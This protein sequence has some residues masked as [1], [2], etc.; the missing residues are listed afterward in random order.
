ML[1]NFIQEK[2]LRQGFLDNHGRTWIRCKPGELSRCVWNIDGE[3]VK[4][5][6]K[7]PSERNSIEY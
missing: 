1:I 4:C 6:L 2:E 7:Y 5:R 3:K